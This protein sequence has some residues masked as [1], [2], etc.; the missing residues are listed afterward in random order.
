MAASH[1]ASA[2]LQTLN[3]TVD[4]DGALEAA[5]EHATTGDGEAPAP[6][7]AAADGG[8]EMTEDEAAT[9]VQ[10][11]YRGHKARK[12][13]EA[14]KAGNGNETSEGAAEQPAAAE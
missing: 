11:L 4:I 12:E 3:A 7:P 8:K 2:H 13:V 1:P 6:E 9:K 10:S 14:M 5:V